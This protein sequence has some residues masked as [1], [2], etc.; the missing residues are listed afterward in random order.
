MALAE[1]IDVASV[2]YNWP[3]ML[4]MFAHV[5]QKATIHSL[6]WECCFLSC[7]VAITVLHMKEVDITLVQFRISM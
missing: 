3:N 1:L 5:L 6:L 2:V 4:C 7:K